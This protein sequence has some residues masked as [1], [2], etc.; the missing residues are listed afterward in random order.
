MPK[1]DLMSSILDY[2]DELVQTGTDNQDIKLQLYKRTG[3]DTNRI[4]I[5]FEM[6][7]GEALNHYLIE[8][9]MWYAYKQVIDT[10]YTLLRIA[11]DFGYERN[12]T[13]SNAFKGIFKVTPS[14]VRKDKMVL[15][16]NRKQLVTIATITEE[17]QEMNDMAMNNRHLS[18]AED[19]MNYAKEQYNVCP[20]TVFAVAEA[21][22]HFGIPVIKL[23]DVCV[24]TMI[25]IQ[26]DPDYISPEI[27]QAIDIGITSSDEMNEIC[28][29]YGCSVF[30]LNELMVETYRQSED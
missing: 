21:A 27:E 5:F 24:D 1:K 4:S 14:K 23:L 13:F 6:Q 9:R 29:Y 28:K 10:D 7:F 2:I 25:E 15:P 11:V 17:E 8:R 26:S 22:S 16:D 19:I 18:E 12:E 20:D 30:D 3:Y